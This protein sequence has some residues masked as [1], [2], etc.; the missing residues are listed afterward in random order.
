[1]P[2][3][4]VSRTEDVG[5]VGKNGLNMDCRNR[6]Q[7]TRRG[8][9][10]SAVNWETFFSVNKCKGGLIVDPSVPYCL[11]VQGISDLQRVP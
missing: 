3:D 7:S 5:T 6:R 4:A 8:V 10:Q 2:R 9:L 11:D 1:M